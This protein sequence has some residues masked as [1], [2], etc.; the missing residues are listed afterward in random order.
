MKL[1]KALKQVMLD[2]SL[3][4]RPVSW[5]GVGYALTVKNGFIYKVPSNM[6]EDAYMTSNLKLI[7]G[8]W[9][10]LDT[11]ILALENE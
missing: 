8:K 1:Q 7:M 3:F 11:K 9:E 2:N 6:G 4:F 5:S 10:V